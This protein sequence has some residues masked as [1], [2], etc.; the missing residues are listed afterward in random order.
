M[1]Y[2][3]FSRC[4]L[5][6]FKQFFFSVVFHMSKYILIS[7]NEMIINRFKIIYRISMSNENE[8]Q[9][10]Q[11]FTIQLLVREI[12][13]RMERP[14]TSLIHLIKNR[15][16]ISPYR[17]ILSPVFYKRI[18]QKNDHCIFCATFHMIF[19]MRYF[20][21]MKIT[22]SLAIGSLLSVYT[23]QPYN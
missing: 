9:D 22:T 11:R 2:Y 10:A 12:N 1:L 7:I 4:I 17:V 3:S 18:L 15:Y 6:N 20:Y 21:S 8:L 19:H 23:L 13:N 14:Y 16:V 5:F